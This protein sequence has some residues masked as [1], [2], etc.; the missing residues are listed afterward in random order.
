MIARFAFDFIFEL[1]AMVVA[2]CTVHMAMCQF[3]I[4]GRAHAGN[5][6]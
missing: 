1:F 6:K 4:G 3:F 2:V 5:F